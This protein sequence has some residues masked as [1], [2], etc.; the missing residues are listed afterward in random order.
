[1]TMVEVSENGKTTVTP[2]SMTAEDA[3]DLLAALWVS[4]LSRQGVDA[5]T[6][7]MG[8]ELQGV[9][10]ERVADEPEQCSDCGAVILGYHACQ[11]V[12]GGFGDDD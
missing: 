10:I 4:H 9:R 11:G 1:M 5:D 8:A 7:A 2:R 6:L 12:P 3:D